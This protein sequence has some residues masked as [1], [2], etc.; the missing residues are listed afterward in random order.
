MI[1][2]HHGNCLDVMRDIPDQ[3][4]D[5]VVTD[6]PYGLSLHKLK[7]VSECL[8]AWIKGKPYAPNKRGYLGETWDAWVP[9]PEVWKECYRVLKPGGHVVAFSGTRSMDLVALGM[10]LAGLELRDNIGYANDSYGAP[11]LAWVY[12]SGM[13]KGYDTAQCI[14]KR[15]TI[16]SDRRPDRNLGGQ[17][18]HLFSNDKPKGIDNTGGK[19]PLTTPEA[20]YWE[21]WG[22]TLKPAWEPIV[23]A[24]RPLAG[25]V[26][27]TVMAHGTGALNIDASRISTDENLN[28][29]AY[30][31][32]ARQREHY[33]STDVTTDARLLSRLNRGN[34]EYV[35]P[36]GRFPANVIHD[37]SPD[38]LE[39]FSL[40]G[41]RPSAKT[42]NKLGSGTNSVYGNFTRPDQTTTV[43]TYGDTGSAAR[44]FFTT[45]KASKEERKGTKHPT[46]KPVALMRYLAVLVTPP[47][48]TILDPFAGS[49]TTGEAAS[50]EG[51]DAILIEREGT[52]VAD[53]KRRLGI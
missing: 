17:R 19:V 43:P 39:A 22:S 44:F 32:S 37:G 50:L 35:A 49:G 4:V 24:R 27:E 53:I 7:D 14:E 25:T 1:T 40:G 21:G 46:V 18:R 15:L 28:G 9:G 38:V 41:E 52:Y 31:G 29:G 16:G 2:V 51:F 36:T 34:G 3:S 30:S 20:Q 13:P 42:V 33:T 45:G 5:S 8:T 47:G 10:R 12:S 11:L 6:P 23:L 26:I 48:G